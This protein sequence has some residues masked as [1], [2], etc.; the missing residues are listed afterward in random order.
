MDETRRVAIKSGKTT[1]VRFDNLQPAT[2]AEP[3]A[4]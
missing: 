3:A 2:E 1:S 4:H